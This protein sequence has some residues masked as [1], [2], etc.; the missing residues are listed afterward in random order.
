MS[1]IQSVL[2]DEMKSRVFNQALRDEKARVVSALQGSV[3]KEL[4]VLDGAPLTFAGKLP[5]IFDFSK[6][7]LESDGIVYRNEAAGFTFRI[8]VDIENAREA[9]TNNSIKK[10]DSFPTA[11]CIKAAISS[12]G[13]PPWEMATIY[14]LTSPDGISIFPSHVQEL[15]HFD[16]AID[17]ETRMNSQIESRNSAADVQNRVLIRVLSM[18]TQLVDND[19]L[20]EKTKKQEA[21]IK[22]KQSPDNNKDGLARKFFRLLGVPLYGTNPN[23]EVKESSRP[24][25]MQM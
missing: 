5:I 7:K 17:Q 3:L 9:K 14:N 11:S 2:D 20:I 12:F 1:V 18:L 24:E 15:R 4:E 25:R 16:L 13:E 8:K 10:D 23:P 6:V 19:F 21:N 22:V